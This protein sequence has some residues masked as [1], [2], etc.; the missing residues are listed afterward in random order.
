[1][2]PLRSVG[3]RLS[4]ALLLVVAGSLALVYLVVI[5]TLQSRLIDSKIH[6]LEHNQ[7][8]LLA[9]YKQNTGTEFFFVTTAADRYNARVAVF[10]VFAANPLTV[11][12]AQDSRGGKPSTDIENDAVVL[13]TAA[14]GYLEHGTVSR[15][16]SRWAE[17]S[18][19]A[20]DGSIIFIS[21]PLGDAL[22]AVS[23]AKQRILI[24]GGLAL[25]LVLVIGYVAAS[26]FARRIR[27]LERAADRIASGSFDEPIVDH[28]QDEIGQ[29]AR[30]FE[31]MRLRLS[32]LDHA[33]REF[34]ANASHE[35]RTPIFSLGGFLELFDDEELD[36]A[37]RAEFLSTMR[38]Q[39]RRLSKLATELLD[40]SRLDAGQIEI[41][42]EPLFLGA[43]ARLVI[44]EYV[45]VARQTDHLLSIDADE[46][47]VALGDEL[48]VVQIVRNLIENALVHTPAGTKVHVEV[49]R[50]NGIVTLSVTDDG[51]GVPAEQVGHVFERFYRGDSSTAS[52]SGLGLAIAL[53]LAR[54]MGG[55]LDLESRPGRTEFLLTLPSVEMV[56]SRPRTPSLEPAEV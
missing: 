7:S 23:V 30:G 14:T 40:L 46:D 29:L 15:D 41:A 3:A 47:A 4:L 8:E 25:V 43:T 28:G 1:M 9:L 16:G 31:R 19:R 49:A 13:R 37:T 12:V 2:N 17:V 53:E 33:R 54:V 24:A 22:D 21:S 18:F 11:N 44:D 35:L 27:R 38:E 36:P 39:V 32:Q 5:P 42:R 10:K 50:G 52:G 48:R 6:Q 34:I 26:M 45:A 51:P 55:T 20:P 56:E